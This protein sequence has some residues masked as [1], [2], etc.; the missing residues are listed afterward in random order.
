M[1]ESLTGDRQLHRCAVAGGSGKPAQVARSPHTRSSTVTTA[2]ESDSVA[3]PPNVALGAKMRIAAGRP[4]C[5][6]GFDRIR[7]KRSKPAYLGASIGKSLYGTCSWWRI[8][9][10]GRI[11][12]GTLFRFA[13]LTP[14]GGGAWADGEDNWWKSMM[15]PPGEPS[16]VNG[17]GGPQDVFRRATRRLTMMK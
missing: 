7:F 3:P 12:T 9:R 10:D 16:S 11:A 4:I 2:L 5:F 17:I 8:C 13:M 6:D 1:W 14:T 15:I